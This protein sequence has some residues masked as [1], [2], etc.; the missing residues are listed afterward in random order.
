MNKLFSQL[1]ITIKGSACLLSLVGVS[2]FWVAP[3]NAEQAVARGAVTIVRPSGAYQ[4]LS[5]ELFLPEGMYFNSGS[6][7]TLIVTPIFTNLGTSNESIKSLSISAGTPASTAT[8]DT[9]PFVSVTG[10]TVEAVKN[11]NELEDAAALI[12]AGNGVQGLSGAME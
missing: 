1:S 10:Q 9:N 3:A 4:S 7:P 6:N 5:G 12:Q 2:N 8:I 11:V